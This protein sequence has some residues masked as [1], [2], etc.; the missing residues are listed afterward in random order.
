MKLSN[1]TR[2]RLASALLASLF[3][4]FAFGADVSVP[5]LGNPQHRL[6]RPDTS[7]LRVLRIITDDSYPPFGFARAD[8]SLTG[9]NVDLAR[10]LCEELKIPCTIQARRWDTL[11][12]A[13]QQGQ[14]DVAIASIAM[15]PA[16][17]RRAD[18]TA[19]YYKTPA[20]FAVR[21]SSTLTE[22]L[23]ESMSGQT[24]GVEGHTAHEA[25]LRTFFPN[26]I[27]RT[28]ESSAALRSA[29]RRGEVDVIF[30]DGVGL[31]LWLAGAEAAQ[32]CRFAGEPFF[33]TQFF[34]EGAGIAVKRDNVIVRRAMDYALKRLDENGVYADLY[35]K[36]FPLG[37]Y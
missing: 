28:Y 23:P 33:D 29:L 2:L 13:L 9:F 4:F 21:Q 3:P 17:L 1:T 6:E 27:L 35:L 34:G 12:D 32:C 15:T 26:A 7:N 24:I 14:A 36:Y 22:T 11:L 19:P 10:A 30:S 31:S 20:R 37:F 18:F 25:Y 5:L 8:G 16:N